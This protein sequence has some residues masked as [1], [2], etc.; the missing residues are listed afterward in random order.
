MSCLLY[1]NF[2]VEI[3][4]SLKNLQEESGHV[5]TLLKFACKE[6][7]EKKMGGGKHFIVHRA[8]PNG[9][10]KPLSFWIHKL[11]VD[12]NSEI[13]VNIQSD[14]HQ[15]EIIEDA[16]IAR[17]LKFFL[18]GRVLKYKNDYG[19]KSIQLSHI[20][21]VYKNIKISPETVV[22]EKTPVSS[23]YQYLP[24]A[25]FPANGD[26]LKIDDGKTFITQSISIKDIMKC[27]KADSNEP[28]TV[29][30]DDL[31]KIYQTMIDLSSHNKPNP[32]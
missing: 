22:V 25:Y 32:P 6:Y 30:T 8:V 9:V 12:N 14:L 2:P 21:P 13:T 18:R 5:N 23:S 19:I 11:I 7:Q 20:E 3:P 16:Y 17:E 10:E 15:E 28:P 27:F 26:F 24:N 1:P 29:D 4:E 31:M